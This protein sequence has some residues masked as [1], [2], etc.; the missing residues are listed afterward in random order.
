MIYVLFIN[1]QS[2]CSI[3]RPDERETTQSMIVIIKKSR[4]A[5]FWKKA[6]N[7]MG[8]FLKKYTLKLDYQKPMGSA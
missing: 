7:E 8:R 6:L 3:L 5:I 2:V 4:Q 1:S